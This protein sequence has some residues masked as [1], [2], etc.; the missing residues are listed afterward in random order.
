MMKLLILIPRD[1]QYSYK[2]IMQSTKFILCNSMNEIANFSLPQNTFINK[3][4]LIALIVGC[5]QFVA[6]DVV[7][8]LICL[9]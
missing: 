9:Y 4:K 7:N 3:L 6:I 5:S 1:N 8:L 2:F